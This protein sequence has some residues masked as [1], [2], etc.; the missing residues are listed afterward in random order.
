[1]S[2]KRGEAFDLLCD[3]A[4][5]NGGDPPEMQHCQLSTC[6]VTR[7]CTDELDQFSGLIV[8][9]GAKVTFFH[10]MIRAFLAA[11]HFARL[12]AMSAIKILVSQL[13]QLKQ[14]TICV[15]SDMALTIV[16][17]FGAAETGLSAATAVSLR[18]LIGLL[19][20]NV[21]GSQ[22]VQDDF[23]VDVVLLIMRCAFE[24]QGVDLCRMIDKE[25]LTSHTLV[26]SVH[27]LEAAALSY[28]MFHTTQQEKYWTVYCSEGS[29]V[30]RVRE[31]MK[32]LGGVMIITCDGTLT[33]SHRDMLVFSKRT[34]QYLATS[35]KVFQTHKSTG[36][37]G[38]VAMPML[39]FYGYQTVEQYETRQRVETSTYFN[40]FKDTILP[41]FQLHSPNRF[42]VCSDDVTAPLT[43]NMDGMC[44]KLW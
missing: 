1:M 25:C 37:K 3:V 31:E 22:P 40:F 11:V 27:K 12:P 39:S 8:Y 6:M 23:S 36:E 29:L 18:H 17:I 34:F 44:S 10:P 14:N 16:Y 20:L 13:C 42:V 41:H 7:G 38:R 30:S 5:K 21:D 24:A 2:S 15:S 4:S 28:Y 43:R 35:V 26:L 32:Q 33:S 19:C 9:S